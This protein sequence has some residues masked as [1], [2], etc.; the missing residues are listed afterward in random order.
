M[1]PENRRSHTASGQEPHIPEGTQSVLSSIGRQFDDFEWSRFDSTLCPANG[2]RFHHQLC[3]L[4]IMHVD[5]NSE[6]VVTQIVDKQ[7]G[8][9]L[10]L[11]RCGHGTRTSLHEQMRQDVGRKRTSGRLAN[12]KMSGF[13]PK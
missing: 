8:N 7:F 3:H 5:C 12:V 6:T 13:A 1:S 2:V 10:E 11:H 9:L 4:Q